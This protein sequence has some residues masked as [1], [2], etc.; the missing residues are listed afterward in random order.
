MGHTLV[1]GFSGAD[2]NRITSLLTEDERKVLCKIPF[3]RDCD[4]DE[5]DRALPYHMTLAHWSAAED[6]LYLP[7][8][9][10]LRRPRIAL[11]AVSAACRDVQGGCL[12]YLRIELL[13]GMDGLRTAIRGM[14]LEPERFLHITLAVDRDAAALR[15]IAGRIH[16]SGALP[17]V[18]HPDR[19]DLYHIWRP[20]RLIRSF[21]CDGRD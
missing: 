7:R 6:P 4:R 12:L 2:L 11:R 19:L 18:L 9:D 14:G 16:A 17:A 8:L 20:V 3:G 13:S 5:A 1:A 10:G 21:P 15:A